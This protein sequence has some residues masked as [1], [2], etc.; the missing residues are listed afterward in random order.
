MQEGSPPIDRTGRP[1][2]RDLPLFRAEYDCAEW[3]GPARTYVICSTPRS[4]STL[5]AELFR[6]T[7]RL[8]SP[9]EYF[10]K[11][12][13]M[14]RMARRLGALSPEGMLDLPAYLR[15]LIRW[16]TSPNGIFGVKVHFQDLRPLLHL[17]A[18]GRLLRTSRLIWI[19]RRD[20][21]AQAISLEIAERTGRWNR[22]RDRV[23]EPIPLAWSH[24]SVERRVGALLEED[25]EWQMLFEA[26]GLTAHRIDHE[27]LIADCEAVAGAAARHAG[28]ADPPSFS[29]PDAP[30]GSQ[31]TELNARWRASY[32]G[33]YALP[34]GS[35]P[36]P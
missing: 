30:V 23:D 29:L 11:A 2:G 12:S 14:P 6:A 18:V 10:N 25:R 8:G 36:A 20:V 34:R 1:K 32:L 7:G 31:R 24:T 15:A 17:E 4:G 19:R 35:A 9:A 28:L 22:V 26:N 3:S 27:D 21:L 13:L 16:R 33:A 5:L